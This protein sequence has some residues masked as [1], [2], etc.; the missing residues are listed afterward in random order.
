MLK[1]LFKNRYRL[2]MLANFGVILLVLA[3]FKLIPEKKVAAL[4]AG[5]LFL[6]S[7]LAILFFEYRAQVLFK[8]FSSYGAMIFLALSAVPIFYLRVANWSEEFS[9]LSLF[10]LSGNQMHEL[11]N[12]IFMLMLV[13]F[14]VDAFRIELKNQKAT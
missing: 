3:F 14:V 5:S 2:Y 12:K 11:S 1:T 8:K 6:I 10:G 4:L 9:S 13:C 7:P